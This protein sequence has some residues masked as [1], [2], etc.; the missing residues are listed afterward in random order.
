MNSASGDN[1]NNK[2]G[3]MEYDKTMYKKPSAAE[4][5]NHLAGRI[6]LF[7]EKVNHTRQPSPGIIEHQVDKHHHEIVDESLM[8]EMRNL[9]QLVKDNGL[10]GD[11]AIQIKYDDL[12]NI[13]KNTMNNDKLNDLLLKTRKHGYIQFS[14]DTLN[15][16]VNI[17]L[18]KVPY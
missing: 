5:K 7:Q 8:N 9:S 1:T 17:K 6:N 18:I 16:D 10:Q 15:E 11:Y 4:K 12:V 3:T 14:G 13:C 2:A